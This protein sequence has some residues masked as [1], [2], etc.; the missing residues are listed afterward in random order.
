MGAEYDFFGHKIVQYGSNYYI[1]YINGTDKKV[2]GESLGDV[3]EK[4]M[5]YLRQIEKEEL[6][7]RISNSLG[8]NHDTFVFFYNMVVSLHSCEGAAIQRMQD[9]CNAKNI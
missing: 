6:Y 8:C 7:S 5:A 9:Y 2:I 1:G 3:K 4:I